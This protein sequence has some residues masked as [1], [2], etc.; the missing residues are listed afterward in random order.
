MEALSNDFCC[1][2]YVISANKI[3][4]YMFSLCCVYR[5]CCVKHNWFWCQPSESPTL[6]SNAELLL[7]VVMK[8]YFGAK[9][10]WFSGGTIFLHRIDQLKFYKVIFFVLKKN[11]KTQ[12]SP[13]HYW[14]SS[15]DQYPRFSGFI[16][17][18]KFKY[19]GAVVVK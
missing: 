12:A 3:F 18:L 10:L 6:W 2:G 7:L 9:L 8:G 11:R 19:N 13:N 1:C 16:S 5:T 17:V 15:I 14:H 4:G